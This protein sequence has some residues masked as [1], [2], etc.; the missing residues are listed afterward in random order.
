M[1]KTMVQREEWQK[2]KKKLTTIIIQKLIFALEPLN[3]YSLIGIPSRWNNNFY[4]AVIYIQN[5]WINPIEGGGGNNETFNDK[6]NIVDTTKKKQKKSHVVIETIIIIHHLATVGTFR[7]VSNFQY[8][9]SEK[10]YDYFEWLT[11]SDQARGQE[12]AAL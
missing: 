3:K 1:Q 7:L 2:K 11:L 9:R 12:P 5:I 6:I 4:R 8:Y 10:F